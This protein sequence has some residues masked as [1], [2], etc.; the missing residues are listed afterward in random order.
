VGLIRQTA[1]GTTAQALT[2]ADVGMN[3]FG[4]DRF[5]AFQIF[6]ADN[7]LRNSLYIGP[8]SNF[9]NAGVF[10]NRASWASSANWMTGRQNLYFGFE[11]N[12]TQMNIVNES[13]QVSTL[14]SQTFADFLR[15]TPIAS[16]FSYLFAGASN[17]YYRAWQAGAFVQ[18]AIKLKSNLNV[19]LGLR[20][21]FNG[22][23]SEKYGH[24]S[25]FHAD[26][27][28]YDAASG[29]VLNSGIVIAGNNA[30]LGTKGVSDSTL[31]GRQWGIG[32][33]VGVAWSPGFA[34]NLTIRAG[35]GVYFDRGE[36]FTYLSPGA[37]RGFSGPF[38]V[39]LQLP[40]VQQV[41]A[42]STATLEAPFGSTPPPPPTNPNAITALLPNFA[43]LKAGGTK[44]TPYLFGGYDAT[45]VLPYT[46]NWSLDLQ[47]Q[48]ANSWLFTLG[49]VGNHGVHQV[50]PI[51]FNQP[52]IATP[53]NPINGEQ[54]SYGFNMIP[55]ETVHTFEG[56]NTDLRVPFLGYSSN[57]VLYKT[58]GISTYNSLQF[59]IRKRLSRGLQF[60]TS[61]TWSHTLDDQS[62][63]GLFYNGND[64]TNTHLS[65]GTSSYDRT[66]VFITSYLYELP[67]F[68]KNSHALGVAAN[69]WQLSGLV[70]AQSGQPFNFYDFSGAVAGQYYSNTV[71]ILDPVIGF[72]PGVNNSQIQ[73]QGTTG[74]N[75][76]QQ[77]IDASKLYIPTLAP[78]THGVPPCTAAG[79]C[80]TVEAAFGSAGRNTF[81][82]PFQTRLDL[83]VAKTFRI[84]DRY[85]LRYSAEAYNIAN[86][87]SFE[88]PNNSTSLYSYNSTTGVATVRTPS[89]TTGFITHTIG[90]PRFLQ[91]SL[92]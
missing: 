36:F 51:P 9:G 32:P 68:A 78:G 5:P 27:Y 57:N 33:R 20:Y 90:S 46:E 83:S 37:G 58:I 44:G 79:A 2:P 77:Y 71:S 31:T 55:T 64:P 15:G 16:S 74:V 21:D 42:S 49:Y 82:G 17:R 11:M 41:S 10:Q 84:S 80:D 24:L 29:T 89:A 63:L 72:T 67:N 60:I 85:S 1:F 92:R 38:G 34:K 91:M 45:N 8:R 76:A 6:T 87:P 28:Q 61:Y 25:N 56:G 19:S 12:Y 52:G 7:V 48:A 40:F 30:T 62:G 70:T 26:A 73:L 39:T 75:P 54:Y 14:E 88:A 22:P 4:S 23:F 66:H 47:Y 59:S 3:I 86:H 13:N 81:R 35:A 53:S 50:L 43:A 18:D 65:Y 69:G